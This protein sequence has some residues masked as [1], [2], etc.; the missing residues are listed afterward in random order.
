MT[1]ISSLSPAQKTTLALLQKSVDLPGLHRLARLLRDP[2]FGCKRYYASYLNR[3][4]FVFDSATWFGF[5][6]GL[7]LVHRDIDKALG[8][9]F[10]L[11][12]HQEIVFF[13]I[14]ANE[15]FVTFLAH[16]RARQMGRGL[17]AYCFDP[18]PDAFKVLQEN[19]GLNSFSLHAYQVAVGASVEEREM[20]FTEDSGNSTL[21]TGSGQQAVGRSV[22]QVTTIDRFCEEYHVVPG[23]IKVDV[24]GYELSVLSGATVTLSRHKPFL[25]ME[26]NPRMLAVGDNSAAA[27][28]MRLR[29][30]G[31][32]PYYVDSSVAKMVKSRHALSQSSR[33]HG[34]YAVDDG[35]QVDK[36]LWDVLAVPHQPTS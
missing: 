13:D 11:I 23:V 5:L 7:G 3:F 27:L 20:L 10:Q 18:N 36:Y 12:P 33:W 4:R 25:V 1:Q 9:L 24:E 28:I 21:L 22:V 2:L 32:D 8:V 14:G 6:T 26:V 35:D 17:D 16:S 30:L 31:Y 19:T 29:Q 15:G 34:Y